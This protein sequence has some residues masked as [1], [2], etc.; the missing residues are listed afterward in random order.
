MISDLLRCRIPFSNSG[1]V[2]VVAGA[3][4]GVL[5][6]IGASCA[7]L[8]AIGVVSDVWSDEDIAQQ[9]AGAVAQQLDERTGSEKDRPRPQPRVNVRARSFGQGS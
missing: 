1:M 2:F 5:D 7:S 4:T 9:L 3:A 6:T 8:D